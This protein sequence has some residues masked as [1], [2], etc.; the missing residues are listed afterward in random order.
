MNGSC[1]LSYPEMLLLGR[2]ATRSCVFK[3]VG[4]FSDRVKICE[5]CLFLI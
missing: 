5:C 4:N 3:Y 1:S 2:N